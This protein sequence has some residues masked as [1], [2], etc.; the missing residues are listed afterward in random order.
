MNPYY[1]VKDGQVVPRASQSQ[2][3][4]DSKDYTVYIDAKNY[5]VSAY[6][7]DTTPPKTLPVWVVDVNYGGNYTIFCKHFGELL[8]VMTLL[9]NLFPTQGPH[10]K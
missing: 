5:Q 6:E 10:R 1:V 8:T 4:L 2:V 7:S 9:A 3:E